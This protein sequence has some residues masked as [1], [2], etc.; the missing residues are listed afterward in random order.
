MEKFQL[1][2]HFRFPW[3]VNVSLLDCF[4]WLFEIYSWAPFI[5]GYM[6]IDDT[7]SKLFCA[8]HYHRSNMHG[9]DRFYGYNST[10]NYAHD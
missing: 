6:C 10:L 5:L 3:P 2:K 7:I 4:L 1:S 9:D 8:S